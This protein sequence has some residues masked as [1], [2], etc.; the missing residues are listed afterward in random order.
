[1]EPPEQEQTTGATPAQPLEPSESRGDRLRRGGRR[2]QL[3]TYTFFIVAF[4]VVLIAL[5]AANAHQVR[6][7][8]VFGHTHASLVWLILVCGVAGWLGGIATALALEWRV[9]RRRR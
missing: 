5:I 9:R 6:Y 1:V 2:V 7:S 4:L 3:Y 8:W